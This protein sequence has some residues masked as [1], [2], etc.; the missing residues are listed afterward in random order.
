[1]TYV[2]RTAGGVRRRGQ[3]GGRPARRPGD[4]A[5]ASTAAVTTA[6]GDD[7]HGEDDHHG[8]GAVERRDNLNDIVLNRLGRGDDD[9]GH[10]GDC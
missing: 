1:M 6:D 7:D 9:A 4:A 8:C 10:D 3:V 5:C 2:M